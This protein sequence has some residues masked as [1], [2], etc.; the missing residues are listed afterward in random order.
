M[1]NRLHRSGFV[2]DACALCCGVGTKVFGIPHEVKKEC[3]TPYAENKSVRLFDLDYFVCQIF[4]KFGVEI[5]LGPVSVK[6]YRG[7]DRSLARP[8]RK[9]ATFPAFYGTWRYI[10]TFTRV[11]HLSLP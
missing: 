4:I 10:T 8:G 11:H 5:P 3:L 1:V 9:E 7:A 6:L 2:K